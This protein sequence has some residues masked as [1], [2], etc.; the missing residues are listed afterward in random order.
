MLLL[1][2][3]SV[4]PSCEIV[5]VGMYERWR[6]L[7]RGPEPMNE[8]FGETVDSATRAAAA[9]RCE[10]RVESAETLEEDW[11]CET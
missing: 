11:A 2:R 1:R 3:D 6:R 4:E 9:R 8:G 5:R 7:E 10:G